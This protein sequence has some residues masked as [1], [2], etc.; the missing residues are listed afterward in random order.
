MSGVRY[1]GCLYGLAVQE[2]RSL[3]TVRTAPCRS[4]D[5]SGIPYPLRLAG[6]KSYPELPARRSEYC[7]CARGQ[8]ALRW[9]LGGEHAPP[10]LL[11]Y[12]SVCGRCKPSTGVLIFHGIEHAKEGTKT[13]MG[14]M[15]LSEP[16]SPKPYRPYHTDRGAE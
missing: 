10:S 3:D 1:C 11:Q 6:R 7:S 13:I 4:C 14:I 15:L 2:G 16:F 5:S 12:A 8:V 9:Q